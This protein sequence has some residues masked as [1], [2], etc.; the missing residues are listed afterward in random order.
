MKK[1]AKMKNQI[2]LDQ[3]G[4][5]IPHEQNIE[6]IIQKHSVHYMFRK[7]KEYICSNCGVIALDDYFHCPRCHVE[8]NT[9]VVRIN[10]NFEKLKQKFTVIV[11]QK[12]PD[13]IIER[14]YIAENKINKVNL[15]EEIYWGEVQRNTLINGKAYSISKYGDH[16]TFGNYNDYLTHWP[17][18]KIEIYPSNMEVWLRDTELKYTTIGHYIETTRSNGDFA[19]PSYWIFYKL[20]FAGRYPWIEQLYKSGL[21]NLWLAMCKDYSFVDMRIFRPSIIKK[22]RAELIQS[23][24]GYAQFYAI[25]HFKKN[26]I[27]YDLDLI[28]SIKDGVEVVDLIKAIKITGMSVAKMKRYM[29]EVVGSCR[30]GKSHYF[31][32]LDMMV[33]I[34]KSEFTEQMAFPK[35]LVESHDDAVMKFNAIK[36]ELDNQEYKKRLDNLKKLGYCNTHL[37][38]VVPMKLEEI[39]FEGK[40]LNHCVGSYVDRVKEGK[41]TI[42]FVRRMDD[43]ESPFFTMEYSG[44]RI[45]QCRGKNNKDAPAEI[46]EFTDEWLKWLKKRNQRK[47]ATVEL[48]T[49]A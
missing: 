24:A 34:Y 12:I 31:D 4:T 49:A 13:R 46:K 14:W 22:Y 3:L 16:W 44:D 42:L 19:M 23:N 29:D 8:L 36:H 47:G 1:M 35:N 33:K 48:S 7:G 9:R 21:K 28:K 20:A 10:T 38:I 41:T 39:L 37:A 15:N 17:Q 2:L 32:Y 45:I 5:M 27:E 11:L 40:K 30:S 43:M 26:K 25:H 18:N 6:E